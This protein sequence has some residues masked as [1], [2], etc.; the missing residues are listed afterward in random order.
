MTITINQKEIS[1]EEIYS[2]V[3][4]HPAN[5]FEE[6][7]EKAMH[8]IVIRELLLQEAQRL[9][10]TPNYTDDQ[11]MEEATIHALWGK[12]LNLPVPDDRAIETFFK[13]NRTKFVTSEGAILTFSDV[14]EEIA[15]YLKDVSWQ[16]ATRE[17]IRLL[18]QKSQISGVKLWDS[19]LE[20]RS[21]KKE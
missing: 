12:V 6:A 4:Y 18:V 20:S 3:Q 16:N 10:V 14:K 17:Y 7:V 1:E 8:S 5:S 15:E 11:S 9:N 2:E 21:N 19:L 13:N